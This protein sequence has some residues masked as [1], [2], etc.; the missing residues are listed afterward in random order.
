MSGEVL[1]LLIITFALTF[2]FT[3][4]RSWQRFELKK[5]EQQSGGR[6]EDSLTTSE[7]R[8]MIEDAVAVANEPFKD[9]L[10]SLAKRLNQ[11]EEGG[12][13]DD[14]R[15]GDRVLLEDEGGVQEKTV[16]R[17]VQQSQR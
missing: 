17:P 10:E 5:L 16:G 7:L 9:D 6:S 2:A 4:F 14:E 3:I 15:G 12:D 13:N 8:E 1:A 11:I